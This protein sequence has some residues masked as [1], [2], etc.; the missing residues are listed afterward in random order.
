MVSQPALDKLF[1]HPNVKIKNPDLVKTKI[2]KFISEGQ[3]RLLVLSDWDFTLSK[4][5]DE[6]GKRCDS[7][8]C[9]FD[10]GARSVDPE[11]CK[12]FIS[13][14]HKYGPIEHN[15]SMTIQEK[16]PYMEEW[17]RQSH[18][19]IINVG[20][21]RQQVEKFVGNSKM[22]LRG[23]CIEL[24]R[25]LQVAKVPLI[26]FSAG[27]GNVI[28]IYLRQTMGEMPR[29]THIVSNM[30]IYGENDKVV[31]FSTPVIHVYCKNSTVIPGNAS[32][33]NEIHGRPNVLLMGDSL[34]DVSM[35]VGAKEEQASLKIGFVNHDPD[36]L[37]EKYMDHFDIVIVMDQSMEVPNLIINEIL[38]SQ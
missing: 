33:A 10:E 26:I 29:N 3:D 31:D 11:F 17:W 6:N 30:M 22:K 28:D 24:M 25:N 15:H 7:C 35:D 34:G 27:I 36:S 14:L 18:N 2:V 5:I 12:R 8:Y 16:V 1:N 20:F 38:S 32:F 4:Y 9:V 37:V 21:T 13:L 23:N 19:E